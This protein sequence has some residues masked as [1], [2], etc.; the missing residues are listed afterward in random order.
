MLKVLVVDD[1][2]LARELAREALADTEFE[3]VEARNGAEALE[4][5]CAEVVC[6]LCDINMPVMDGL[7]FLEALRDRPNR[8]PV[9]VVSTESEV[10]LVQR[11]RELGA[12]GWMVKPLQK[13]LLEP[14][15]RK[16]VDRY[17]GAERCA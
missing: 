15:V 7:E 9:L 5:L 4:R 13:A 8:P 10:D 17:R 1:S 14:T 3:I 11:A 2:I 12:V 6:V 16:L